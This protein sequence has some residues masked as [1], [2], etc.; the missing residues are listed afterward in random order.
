[1]RRSSIDAGIISGKTAGRFDGRDRNRSR[2][3]TTVRDDN[4]WRGGGEVG[5]LG[6]LAYRYVHPSADCVVGWATLSEPTRA[7][8]AT[9]T[10]GTVTL[11]GLLRMAR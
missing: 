1:M 5:G 4:G 10:E 2:R 3:A 6:I 11:I 8:G 9:V 7:V